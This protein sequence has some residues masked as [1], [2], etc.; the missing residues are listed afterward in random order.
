M[1]VCVCV[2]VCVCDFES[3]LFAAHGEWLSVFLSKNI[4]RERERERAA[5]LLHLD[6]PAYRKFMRPHTCT[7]VH[8]LHEIRPSSPH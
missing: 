5:S 7:V 6:Q 2:C 8:S 4:E 3:S 1:C